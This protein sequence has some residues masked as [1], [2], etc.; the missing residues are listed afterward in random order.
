MICRL[1]HRHM[2]RFHILGGYL[3]FFRRLS[4]VFLGGYL[5]F[6]RAAI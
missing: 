2:S 6:F 3:L 5:M 4:D 1:L